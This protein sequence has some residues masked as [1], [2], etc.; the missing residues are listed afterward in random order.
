MTL[1]ATSAIRIRAF[2]RAAIVWTLVWFFSGAIVIA[3]G[4]SRRLV[5]PPAI[6]E[7]RAALRESE[8]AATGW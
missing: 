4:L 1:T 2:P 6:R 5:L 7:R 8:I 3:M